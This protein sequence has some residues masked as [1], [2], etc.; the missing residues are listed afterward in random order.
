MQCGCFCRESC[1]LSIEF[2]LDNEEN[3]AEVH[4]HSNKAVIVKPV[5]NTFG[6]ELITNHCQKLILTLLEAPF[7]VKD[8]SSQS[9]VSPQFRIVNLTAR[10]LSLHCQR[11]SL[12]C[13][14]LIFALPEICPHSQI[15][16][17]TV[18]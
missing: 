12:R 1:L 6:T 5:C 16:T 2:T 7:P 18:G 14:R 13:Q 11:L 9:D 8:M 4:W 17:H 3:F 15:Y 10:N